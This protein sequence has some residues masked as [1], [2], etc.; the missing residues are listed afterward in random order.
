MCG[1]KTNVVTAIEI[2]GPNTNDGTQLPALVNA[3]ARTFPI[4]DVSADKAYGTIV[5]A[6][7]IASKGGHTKTTGGGAW[8]KMFGYFMYRR[9][10]F[11]AHYHQRSNVETTFSMIKRKFGHSQRCSAITSSCSF[12]RC[13]SWVLTRCFGARARRPREATYGV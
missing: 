13:T 9:E 6:D 12:M 3:T 11:M 4:G 5:N 1:V 2:H 10:E 7:T 8:G